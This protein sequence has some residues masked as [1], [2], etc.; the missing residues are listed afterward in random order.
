MMVFLI[1]FSTLSR[2]NGRV[3]MVT[4]SAVLECVLF[5]SSTK[6]IEICLF[7]FLLIS[8]RGRTPRGLVESCYLSEISEHLQIRK[9]LVMLFL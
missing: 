6:Q 5:R 4:Q 3:S 9:Y 2:D 7:C 1:S 8:G